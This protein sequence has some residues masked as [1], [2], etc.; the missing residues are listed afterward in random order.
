[1]AALWVTA[2][3]LAVLF[4]LLT[5]AVA[6]PWAPLDRLD[7]RV[8]DGGYADTY[9]HP[10][11]TSFWLTVASWGQ[12]VVQ[13]GL[14]LVLAVVLAVRHHRSTAVW[15]VALVVVENLVAPGMKHVLNRPRPE[16][17]NPITVEHSTSFP[18][19]H[20]TAAATFALAVLLVLPLLIR[21]RAWRWVVGAVTVVVAL[22]ICADRIMLGVH[23]LS[24]VVGGVLLGG[25]LAVASWA[26]LTQVDRARAARAGAAGSVDGERPQVG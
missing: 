19:G 14:M 18:S 22:L 26:V 4:V 17:D 5:A 21:S 25:L 24:D 2:A 15:L 23:Y 16:W 6:A 9:R 13:R 3:V 8:A 20:A 7:V 1:M 11:L 10:H 12:P